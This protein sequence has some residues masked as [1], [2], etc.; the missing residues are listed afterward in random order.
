MGR[1]IS[2]ITSAGNSTGGNSSCFAGAG[3][4][5]DS[6]FSSRVRSDTPCRGQHQR[7]GTAASTH[8]F[9][10]TPLSMLQFAGTAQ[11]TAKQL[12]YPIHMM[13]VQGDGW[14]M[15]NFIHGDLALT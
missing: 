3:A 7:S 1:R 4:G 9:V 5:D 11:A 8:L 6:A 12:P 2:S 14:K 13:D 15:C 10:C